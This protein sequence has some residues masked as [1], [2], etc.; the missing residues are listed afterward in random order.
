MLAVA[1]AKQ[2]KDD[3]IHDDDVK[4]L[5]LILGVWGSMMGRK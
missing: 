3:L 4:D 1:S 2:R 5:N